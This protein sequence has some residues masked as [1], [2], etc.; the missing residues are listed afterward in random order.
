MTSDSPQITSRPLM[1]S[2]GKRTE[3]PDARRHLR[4]SIGCFFLEE[5]IATLRL[6]QG[7]TVQEA[8]VICRGSLR[9]SLSPANPFSLPKAQT[10]ISDFFLVTPRHTEAMPRAHTE[11]FFPIACAP[12]RH[13]WW[14]WSLHLP[15]RDSLTKP[16]QHPALRHPTKHAS[17]DIFPS[18]K[19]ST[20]WVSRKRPESLPKYVVSFPFPRRLR[21]CRRKLTLSIRDFFFSCSRQLHVWE[22][23]L[24]TYPSARSSELL[25]RTMSDAR[26]T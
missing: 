4:R 1:H 19:S 18:H 23:Q 20:Q 24:L 22:V 2:Q 15:Y 11:N 14:W 3:I 5:E 26:R 12:P 8:P 21:A 9:V 16:C 17:C 25:A 6:A 13:M 7:P 10:H